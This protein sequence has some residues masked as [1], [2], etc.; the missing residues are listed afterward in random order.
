MFPVAERRN[1]RPPSS[2]QSGFTL[3]E[4][5]VAVVVLGVGMLGVAALQV[6]ALKSNQSSLQRTQAV[7]MIYYMLDAMRANRADAAN[8]LY[9]MG[10]TCVV[11]TAAPTSLVSNDLLSWLQ[12]LKDNIGDASTTCGEI[13]CTSGATLC[14][15][16]VYWDD[17]RGA[18]GNAAEK[19]E[20]ATRL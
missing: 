10:K 20:I 19:F 17:T 16:A 15:V 4:V 1:P 13:D 6:N 11:P 2:R 18:G 7:T 9:D 12:A 8:Q 14:K 5:L 3:L